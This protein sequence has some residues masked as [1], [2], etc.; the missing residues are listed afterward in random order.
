M[1]ELEFIAEIVRKTGIT[2]NPAL[3]I[4]IGDDCALFSSPA[5][6]DLLVTADMLVEEVHFDTRWHD[7][8]LLGRKSIAV[9]ISDIAAMGGTPRF[10]LLSVGLSS[11]F[12]ADWLQ[13]FT[14]GT[15][16]MLAEHQCSLI[17]GDTVKAESLTISVTIIGSVETGREIRRESAAVGDTIFCSGP[18]GLAAAG[19]HICREEKFSVEDTRVYKSQRLMQSHLNPVPRTHYGKCLAGSGCVSAMQDISDG[20]ATD[21]S[22]ICTA[23]GVAAVVYE[24]MLP[25]HPDLDDL[26]SEKGL[27]PLDFQLKGGEDYELLFT[28]TAGLEEQLKQQVKK[29][30]GQVPFEIGRIKQGSGVVL[31]TVSGRTI[32]IEYQGYEHTAL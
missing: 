4:G 1:R 16:D 28:V 14:R 25:G 23:S 31:E 30:L 13:A 6:E 32:D 3:K 11:R 29:A 12:S 27:N 2:E 22:H 9:N 24:K 18:L 26:C 5:G 8:Y 7:P 17:G 15:L 21:L 10:A 19:L 20:I